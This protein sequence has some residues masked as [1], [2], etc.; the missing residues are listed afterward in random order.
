MPPSHT[1]SPRP[2]GGAPSSRE[3]GAFCVR[4]A[5]R[6]PG[7]AAVRD[8][9]RLLYALPSEGL[10]ARFAWLERL[11]SWLPEPRPAHGLVEADKPE[12]PAAASRLALLL[13]VLEG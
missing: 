6:A 13:R 7:H 12:T 1:T 10:E 11:I 5:P 3:G 4:Y 8:L 9:C 2:P